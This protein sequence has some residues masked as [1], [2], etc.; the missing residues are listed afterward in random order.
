[1]HFSIREDG[2]R[3]SSFR[4]Y[5][6]AS[7]V[8]H[9]SEQLHICT[10]TVARKLHFSPSDE[11]LITVTGVELEAVHGKKSR[12]ISARKEVILAC[13]ALYTPQ[14]LLLR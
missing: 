1:M 8:N 9:A 5:L 12:T 4:A 11:G 10:E 3:S 13:G 2:T 7:F 6:P 14:L